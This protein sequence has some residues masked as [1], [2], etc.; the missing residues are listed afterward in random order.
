MN[1]NPYLIPDKKKNSKC[2]ILAADLELVQIK[3]SNYL[4]KIKQDVHL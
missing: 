4:I 3:E 2:V 1:H